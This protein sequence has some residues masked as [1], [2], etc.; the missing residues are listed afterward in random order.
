MSRAEPAAAAQV[1][2]ATIGRLERGDCTPIP[3]TVAALAR[4]LEVDPG[5]LFPEEPK[6]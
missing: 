1:H 6:P 3:A 4:A 5:Q 2:P